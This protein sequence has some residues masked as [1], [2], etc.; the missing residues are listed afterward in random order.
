MKTNGSASACIILFF[1]AL[2]LSGLP[3]PVLGQGLTLATPSTLSQEQQVLERELRS[4]L[5]CTCGTCPHLSLNTCVCPDADLMRHQLATQIEIG[6]DRD[7]IF[8]YFIE[9][10]GSQEPLGT[11]IGAFNQLAWAVPYAMGGVGLFGLIMAA[12]RIRKRR[13][14]TEQ[15]TVKPD[16]EATPG[17]ATQGPYADRLEEE[18]SRLD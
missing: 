13:V 2:V 10:Y 11:P 18:L 12:Q 5:V 14:A 8:Q 1:A 9:T 4:E 6:E 7:G 16:A 17:H 15:S 3:R